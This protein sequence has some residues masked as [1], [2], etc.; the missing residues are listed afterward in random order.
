V[1]ATIRC[2]EDRLLLVLSGGSQAED[3]VRGAVAPVTL[4]CRWIARAQRDS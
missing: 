1:A 3:V 2:P 4:L